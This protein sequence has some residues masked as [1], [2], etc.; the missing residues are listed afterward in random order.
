AAILKSGAKALSDYFTS[1]AGRAALARDG[2]PASVTVRQ[3]ALSG[4][5]LVM[6]MFDREVGEYWRAVLGLRGRLVSVSVMAPAMSSLSPEQSRALLEKSITAIRA[7][8]GS[9]V[10]AAGT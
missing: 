7:A 10:S 9:T 6:R 8:N 5:A 2:D 3:T 1:R 4:G